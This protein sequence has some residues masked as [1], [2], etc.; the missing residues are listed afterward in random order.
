MHAVELL[1]L[2]PSLSEVEIAIAQLKK[3]KSPGRETLQLEI[4]TLVNSIW[5]KEV[6]P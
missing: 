3:Y 4:H 1:V 5:N 2:D 6:L